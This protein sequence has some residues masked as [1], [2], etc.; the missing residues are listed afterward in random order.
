MFLTVFIYIRDSS[1]HWFVLCSLRQLFLTD[2][3]CIGLRTW[4]IIKQVV[5]VTSHP[6]TVV[7]FWIVRTSWCPQPRCV[8]RYDHVV[9]CLPG[10]CNT[11]DG[12]RKG[13]NRK[14]T[15]NVTVAFVINA[16]SHEY[17]ASQTNVISWPKSPCLAFTI[18]DMNRRS[19]TGYYQ[20]N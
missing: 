10:V 11:I 18:S 20:A 13:N 6:H 14:H 16:S 4:H 17:G 9:G 1:L 7:I 19:Q 12:L 8:S 15:R 3:V 5:I 2:N